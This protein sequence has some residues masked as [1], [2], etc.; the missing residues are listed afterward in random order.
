M[1][2]WKISAKSDKNWGAKKNLVK[3][4]FIEMSTAST[5]PPL[6]LTKYYEDIVRAFN[7]KYSTDFDKSKI[8]HSYFVCEKIG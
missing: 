5:T 7:V 2:L 1:A 4:M 6:N 8:G 3:G